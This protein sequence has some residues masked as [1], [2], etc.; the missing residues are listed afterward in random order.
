MNLYDEEEHSPI[1]NQL[2]KGTDN[3][4]SGMKVST[5]SNKDFKDIDFLHNNDPKK[6]G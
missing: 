5:K 3:I 6:S 4:P 1:P 2:P